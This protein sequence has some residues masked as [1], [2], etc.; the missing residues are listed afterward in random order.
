MFSFFSLLVT[1]SQTLNV[2]VNV[3]AEI[4]GCTKMT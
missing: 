1:T 4:N 3:N 2:N